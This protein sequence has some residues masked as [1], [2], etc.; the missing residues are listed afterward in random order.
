MGKTSFILSNL[1]YD[2]WLHFAGI[3][4]NSFFEQRD[5]F[6]VYRKYG[7][8][9]I[10]TTSCDECSFIRVF[11][12]IGKPWFTKIDRLGPDT[13]GWK[14]IHPKTYES[15]KKYLHEIEQST[16]SGSAKNA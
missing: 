5:H 7:Y 1:T 3:I 6:I 15:I 4:D 2:Q 10:K 14:E 8:Y 11:C 12:E 16:A 13:D 9:Y